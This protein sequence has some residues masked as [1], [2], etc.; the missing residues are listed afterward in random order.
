[1]FQLSV[2]NECSCCL[3][4]T[5]LID[6]VDIKRVSVDEEG[7]KG[8]QD[9]KCAYSDQCLGWKSVH[10]CSVVCVVC[11]YPVCVHEGGHTW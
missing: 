2:I 6:R 11:G 9:D 10:V 5:Y 7:H 3:E 4:Q 8:K 1:M